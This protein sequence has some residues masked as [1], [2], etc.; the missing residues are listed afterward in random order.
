MLLKNCKILKNSKFKKV[1]I[2]IVPYPSEK[3]VTEK[4]EKLNKVKAEIEAGTLTLND[5]IDEDVIQ[6]F[7]AKGI[8]PDGVIPNFIYDPEIAKAVVSSG[9][10]KVGIINPNKA[11]IVVFQKTKEV[12]AEDANFDKSKEQVKSDYIN[13]KVAEYMSKLF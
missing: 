3:T 7:D 13:N 11:T 6:S 4:L 5:K 9:L 10:N 12:K 1:D 8:T 2:L